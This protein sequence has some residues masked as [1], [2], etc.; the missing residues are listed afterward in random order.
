MTQRSH[1]RGVEQSRTQSGRAGGRGAGGRSAVPRAAV[2]GKGEARLDFEQQ[3]EGTGPDIV[4][5]P[6]APIPAIIHDGHFG[7]I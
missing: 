3:W 6:Q 5:C 7:C 2:G 4:F 1:G